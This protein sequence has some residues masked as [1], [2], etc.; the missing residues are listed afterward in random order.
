MDRFRFGIGAGNVLLSSI[1]IV[2]TRRNDVYVGVRTFAASVKLSIHGSGVS[3]L[4][5]TPRY[6]EEVG[7]KAVRALPDRSFARWLG[8]STVLPVRFDLSPTSKALLG[9][10][11]RL[12]R[13]AQLLRS[14]VR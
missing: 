3:Q 7:A 11:L 1:W 2:F 13:H 4:A 9:R 6:W 8:I 12:G 10:L 14:R 5:L